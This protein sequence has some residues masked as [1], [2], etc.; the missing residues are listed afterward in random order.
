[1]ESTGVR[2]STILSDHNVRQAFSADVD[3]EVRALLDDDGI[4]DPSLRDLT[5]LPFVTIDNDDSRDLDQALYLKRRDDGF[6]VWYALADAAWYV[7][8][9][10]ALFDEALA[11]GASFYLPGA[12]VPMLPRALSED[13]VSLNPDVDRRALTFEMHL[14]LDGQCTRTE[15]YR[16]RIHSR[17]KLSYPGVQHSYDHPDD[18]PLTH[19]AYMPSL[20]L[21]REVGRLKMEDARRRGVIRF[22]RQEIWLN[23]AHEDVQIA[24]EPR[25]DVERYNE[26]ISLMCNIE[27]AK[28]LSVDPDLEPHVQAVY[29]V[30]PAPPPERLAQVARRVEAMVQAHDLD[31]HWRWRRGLCA[32]VAEKVGAGDVLA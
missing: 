30:H 3:D 32:A 18:S 4:D 9:G 29:R 1:M 27:G 14:D 21:L 31:D 12:C 23:T 11:R 25:L 17:A 19:A 2:V 24:Y 5:H 15:V 13:L 26:Q 22:D 8:P 16:A 10:T 6:V 20:R 7:R 28:L